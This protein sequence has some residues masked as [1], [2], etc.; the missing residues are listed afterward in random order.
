MSAPDKLSFQVEGV[1]GESVLECAIGAEHGLLHDCRA[2]AVKWRMPVEL[3]LDLVALALYD[4]VIYA[5]DSTSMKYAESGAR[6]DD[7]KMIL[8]R[9]TEV[10]TLLDED[11]ES[12]P[13]HCCFHA[14]KQEKSTLSGV[15]ARAFVSR[16][17]SD[18][19]HVYELCDLMPTEHQQCECLCGATLPR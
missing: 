9:V 17:S 11:G 12:S 3:A 19:C 4:I 15:I 16:S 8:Q 18:Y 7:L 5:D 1:E 2:L 14:T 10:A 13:P 6:I